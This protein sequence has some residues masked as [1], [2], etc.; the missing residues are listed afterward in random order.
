MISTR[1]IRVKV[2]DEMIP[3][4]CCDKFHKGGNRLVRINWR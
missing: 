2:T 1:I 4:E 3:K